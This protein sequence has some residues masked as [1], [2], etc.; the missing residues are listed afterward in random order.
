MKIKQIQ[1]RVKKGGRTRSSKHELIRHESRSHMRAVSLIVIAL[2]LLSTTIL[3]TGC[4]T[5]PP[6]A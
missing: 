4:P 5:L 2:G 3:L 1:R 6:K